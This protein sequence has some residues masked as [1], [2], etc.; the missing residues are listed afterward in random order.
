[1]EVTAPVF[2]SVLTVQQIANALAGVGIISYFVL[3]SA[4]VLAERSEAAAVKKYMN[5]NGV[6]AA[7]AQLAASAKGKEVKNRRGAKEKR[8]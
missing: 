5:V 6:S 8:N 2:G 1:M 3:K 7:V 4:S